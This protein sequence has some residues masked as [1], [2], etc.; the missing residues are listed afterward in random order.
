MTSPLRIVDYTADRLDRAGIRHIPGP[1]G[2]GI[3]ELDDAIHQH[4]NL[5][6][7][8]PRHEFSA[9]SIADQYSRSR[10]SRNDSIDAEAIVGAAAICWGGRTP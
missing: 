1:D 6:P 4:S 5:T 10:D 3:E 2:T 7:V 8:L 9:A